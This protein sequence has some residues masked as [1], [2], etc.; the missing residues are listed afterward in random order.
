[1]PNSENTYFNKIRNDQH[2]KYIKLPERAGWNAGRAVLLSQVT[3]EYFVSCDDDFKF[4]KNTDLAKMLEVIARTG[5][6][7][8]GGGINQ[9]KLTKWGSVGR[10]RIERGHSGH[11][12]SRRP[13]FYGALGSYPDCQVGD[14]IQ[15]F[16]IGRTLT[17]GSIRFDPLF[18]QIAHQEYFLDGTGQLRIAVW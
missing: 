13:G 2:V 18:T 1:M 7:I 9:S 5:F 6:D 14:I 10:F 16:F 11:C 15:N 4:N 12:V 8:I 3:T 17:A